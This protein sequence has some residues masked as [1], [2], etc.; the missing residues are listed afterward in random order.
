VRI[1][2]G[3]G[4]DSRIYGITS[5]RNFCDSHA[6]SGQELHSRYVVSIWN[7]YRYWSLPIGGCRSV[8]AFSHV[9][10]GKGCTRDVIHWASVGRKFLIV[11]QRLTRVLNTETNVLET[12]DGEPYSHSVSLGLLSLATATYYLWA[13]CINRA[14]NGQ[15]WPDSGLQQY[16]QMSL[17]PWRL[18]PLSLIDTGYRSAR[19]V[20]PELHYGRFGT[21]ETLISSNPFE[22]YIILNVRS[23]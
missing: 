22:A 10:F 9:L 2:F 1:R 20:S 4:L 19:A 12:E 23:G 16:R 6:S 3:C 7:A 15:Q 14:I 21:H 5:H 17:K 18:G 8:S 13:E 11:R